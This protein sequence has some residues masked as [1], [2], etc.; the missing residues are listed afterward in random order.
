VSP[1][2]DWVRGTYE[3]SLGALVRSATATG[4]RVFVLLEPK[5]SEIEHPGIDYPALY[6]GARRVAALEGAEVIDPS[7]S[8]QWAEQSG[9]VWWDYAH[10]TDF[11]YRVLAD[12]VARAI[13][14]VVAAEEGAR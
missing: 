1:D 3:R 4:A 9:V 13:L 14:R 11:G 10:M 5:T 6:D 7:R 8:I 2:Y 12:D